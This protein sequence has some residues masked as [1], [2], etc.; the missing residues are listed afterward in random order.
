MQLLLTLAEVRTY[1]HGRDAITATNYLFNQ[2]GEHWDD[3]AWQSPNGQ[4][5]WKFK[6]RVAVLTLHKLQTQLIYH[7]TK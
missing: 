7:M 5:F 1:K 3:L 4:K 6:Q 2:Y